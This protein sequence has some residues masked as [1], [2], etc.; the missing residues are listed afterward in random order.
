MS[1]NCKC[2]IFTNEAY[3][4]IMTETFK[5]DPLETGGILLGHVLENGYWIVMEVLPPGWRS[6]FEYAYFEYDD[7]FVNYV[8]QNESRKYKQRLSVLGLWHRHPGS[9]D[10]FSGTDD[11]T[12]ATFAAL[13]PMGAISGLVNIDPRFRLTMF[14]VGSPLQYEKVDVEVGDDLIPE[15]YFE[16]NY[17]DEGKELNPMPAALTDDSKKKELTGIAS[18]YD[19]SS[20]E[21]S[22]SSRSRL[23][24]PAMWL[25]AACAAASLAL[26]ILA[27]QTPVCSSVATK[28]DNLPKIETYK[29]IAAGT[30]VAGIILALTPLWRKK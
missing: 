5:K 2:V 16:L 3:N 12:N 7:E 10:T 9:M 4:A 15:E 18:R 14:H 30:Q 21:N 8:A 6:T 1:S 19:S 25:S 24:R 28:K 13:S 29:K 17:Y 26:W 27:W 23:K 11:R 22:R 20:S